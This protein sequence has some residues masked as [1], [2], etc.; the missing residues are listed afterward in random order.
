MVGRYNK[1]HLTPFA[2]YPP[3]FFRHLAPRNRVT[4]TPGHGSQVFTI[5]GI[6]V[7]GFICQEAQVPSIVRQSVRDGAQLLVST[8]NDS[9]FGNSA[10]A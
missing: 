5:H 6:P 8:G 3:R 10:I 9:I 2:E 7:G 1:Q 4:F